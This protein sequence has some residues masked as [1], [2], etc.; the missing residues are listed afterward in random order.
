MPK[1][2]AGLILK[3]LIISQLG[4]VLSPVQPR[5]T[6]T[7]HGVHLNWPASVT[8]SPPVTYNVYRGTVHTGPYTKIAGSV[9]GT[10]YTDSVLPS[11]TTYYYVVT[12]QN[13][14]GESANS[15]E[16]SATTL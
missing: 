10:A 6:P 4:I 7:L 13:I 14:N 12:S 8:V 2:V 16:A 15:P 1:L 9:T 11:S 5:A 3:C